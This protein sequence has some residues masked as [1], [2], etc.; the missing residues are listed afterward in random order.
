MAPPRSTTTSGPNNGP[1]QQRAHRNRKFARKTSNDQPRVS[2]AWP[3]SRSERATIGVCHHLNAHE[4]GARRVSAAPPSR[5]KFRET[6]ST[7]FDLRKMTVVNVLIKSEPL[8]ARVAS[9]FLSC[10]LGLNSHTIVTT[11]PHLSLA[12]YPLCDGVGLSAPLWLRLGHK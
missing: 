5:R 4:R 2:P 12:L 1:P 3:T 7:V 11:R 8:R 6:V 10:E 9:F